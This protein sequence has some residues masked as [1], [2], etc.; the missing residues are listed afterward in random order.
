MF[1]FNGNT[2]KK[3]L[4]NGQNVVKLMYRTFTTWVD[5]ALHS[6]VTTSGNTKA[7]ELENATNE[8]VVEAKVLAH[9][10]Q[11]TTP[12]PEAPTS[13]SNTGVYDETTGKYKVSCYLGSDKVLANYDAIP[14]SYTTSAGTMTRQ[15]N[16]MH[17]VNTTSSSTAI[18]IGVTIK[19][20]FPELKIGDTIMF[21]IN[22]S[23]TVD[24]IWIQKPGLLKKGGIITVTQ[25]MLDSTVNC[26]TA[27][28]G[29]L[30]STITELSY[31]K[32]VKDYTV[33]LDE[34]LRRVWK[35][36]Y[37]DY[38]DYV[39]KKVVRNCGKL[40]I[41]GQEP[42]WY[43]NGNYTTDSII[44]LTNPNI[45]QYISYHSS[46]TGGLS[47]K[48]EYYS[49]SSIKN[50]FRFSSGVYLFFTVDGTKYTKPENIATTT[51]TDEL[52]E[53][54]KDTEIIYLRKTPKEEV[55]ELPDMELSEGDNML[56]TYYGN[57]SAPLIKCIK[58][59]YYKYGGN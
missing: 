59:T 50:K 8:L 34:P 44:C 32:T 30:K 49:Y 39:N 2:P 1:K 58:V 40:V 12:T 25:D 53:V 19:E 35:D 27:Y 21:N 18:S 26:Y 46:Y 48:F 17:L 29:T 16:V 45:D 42:G 20:I 15:G 28:S 37:C 9:S 24:H 54:I 14:E 13:I 52:R 5:K 55:L 47:N 36:D 38:V 31:Y 56:S 11:D 57:E 7:V 6:I 4:F 10:Y 33:Y 41:T 3:I 22:T 43:I 51:M 23:S